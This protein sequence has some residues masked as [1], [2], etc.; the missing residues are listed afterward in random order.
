MHIALYKPD[1]P[2]NTAAII[3]LSACLNLKIHIIEP[4]GFSLN[5]AR[6]K[7]VVMDYLGVCKI[8]KYED[9]NNFLIKNRKKRIVL[10]TTKAKKKYHEFKFNKNDI[11]LFGR[12]SAGVPENLH[13]TI[14]NK[15]K[16]PINKK[17]RSLNVA[18]SVAIISA[19]A[20][21]Q[22]NLLK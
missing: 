2:Q 5:D 22:N 11:L 12:E 18:M 6:F 8:F 16:V 13:K 17:T 14:K 20:L 3:R 7:R 1:I 9:Y 19:E 10:M 4:C 15:V 21:R